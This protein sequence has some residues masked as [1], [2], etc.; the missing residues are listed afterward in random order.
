MG[1]DSFDVVLAV[2]GQ[3]LSLL[4]AIIR[5][6]VQVRECRERE[7]FRAELANSSVVR[8]GGG[9]V[10]KIGRSAFGGRLGR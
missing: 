9:F 4:S 3:A 2:V 5:A 10:V 7:R 8:A 1:M 6:W